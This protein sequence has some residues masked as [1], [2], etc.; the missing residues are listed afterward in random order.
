MT[1]LRPETPGAARPAAGWGRAGA[2][3]GV[4]LTGSGAFAAYETHPLI[5]PGDYLQIAERAQQ[6]SYQPPGD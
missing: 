5:E 4:G 6:I 1:S 3:T 2:Q